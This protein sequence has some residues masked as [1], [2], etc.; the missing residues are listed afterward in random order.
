MTACKAL[1]VSVFAFCKLSVKKCE[2]PWRSQCWVEGRGFSGSYP[3]H[4]VCR[5]EQ[6]LR[7][8]LLQQ[9][10]SLK[11]SNHWFMN[12]IHASSILTDKSDLYMLI[13]L[14]QQGNPDSQTLVHVLLDTLPPPFKAGVRK[15]TILMTALGVL[16]LTPNIIR[17]FNFH[18]KIIS[19]FFLSN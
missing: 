19:N 11:I 5:L 9:T 3:V 6:K 4:L 7:P 15:L 1:K 16:P 8:P 14:F 13:S 17:S 12:K 18:Y 2:F 10:P